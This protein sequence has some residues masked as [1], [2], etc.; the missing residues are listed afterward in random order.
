MGWFLSVFCL[1]TNFCLASVL[2]T[3]FSF[4]HVPSF[5]SRRLLPVQTNVDEHDPANCSLYREMGAEGDLGRFNTSTGEV[6]FSS[7]GGGQICPP[8]TF[9]P[10]PPGVSCTYMYI[11]FYV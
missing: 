5:P 6:D 7:T 3:C 11:A 4:I 9:T 8:A 10:A 1:S 2:C